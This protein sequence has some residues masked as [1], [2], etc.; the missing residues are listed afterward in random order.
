MKPTLLAAAIAAA[1]LA[2]A[3]AFAQNAPAPS[4]APQFVVPPSN[5]LDL[6]DSPFNAA[7]PR[8]DV[9][10][11]FNGKLITGANRSGARTVYVQEARGA[12]FRLKLADDCQALAA[13]Q[14]LTVR[15]DGDLVCG[16]VRATMRVQTP[17]GFKSCRVAHV[18]RLTAGE[19][20]ALDATRSGASGPKRYAQR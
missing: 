3:P 16:G 20:K 6:R 5:Y 12:I 2:G 8:R 13:A 9:G 11:C 10:Q 7:D 4:P 1:V 19:V 15:S 14:K 17:A 18:R